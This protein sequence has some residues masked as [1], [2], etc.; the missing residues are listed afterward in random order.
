MPPISLIWC[1]LVCGYALQCVNLSIW[2]CARTVSVCV[3][4]CDRRE[5]CNR[6]WHMATV[7]W[8]EDVWKDNDSLAAGSFSSLWTGR[9]RKRPLGEAQN[10]QSTQ[11]FGEMSKGAVSPPQMRILCLSSQLN[12]VRPTSRHK[13]HWKDYW[14][15]REGDKWRKKPDNALFFTETSHIENR[16]G[17]SSRADACG[18]IIILIHQ[19]AHEIISSCSILPGICLWSRTK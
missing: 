6:V 7:N 13:E 9:N 10:H 11:F 1:V 14:R 16:A 15:G 18:I 8:I 17:F 2:M 19:A 4:P 12:T 5:T 3:H